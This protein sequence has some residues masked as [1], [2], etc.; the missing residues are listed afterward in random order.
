MKQREYRQG[1]WIL[2]YVEFAGDA[3]GDP[4]GKRLTCWLDR[5][6]NER[7]H[8]P[9]VG[10]ACS[11]SRWRKGLDLELK[12]VSLGQFGELN[13]ELS[14]RGRDRLNRPAVDGNCVKTADIVHSQDRDLASRV[15]SD[16]AKSARQSQPGRDTQIPAS[17]QLE[18]PAFRFGRSG[19]S[20]LP[21]AAKPDRM[22]KRHDKSLR[23]LS[24]IAP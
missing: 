23:A 21:A 1:R 18:P 10:L 12:H 3:R 9:I 24:G 19:Y 11:L 2:S 6:N 22:F 15:K 7:D 5:A 17:R 13:R 4:S 14:G 8:A 16:S 20:K